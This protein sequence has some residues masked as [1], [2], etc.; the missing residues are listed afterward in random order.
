MPP[1]DVLTTEYYAGN[2]LSPIEAE[3]L[4][5]YQLLALQLNTL[6]AEIKKLNSA[7]DQN[8]LARNLSSDN[9]TENGALGNADQLVDNLR[10]L[11]MKMGLVY[12][13]FKGAVYSLFLQ[14]EEDQNLKSDE[15]KRLNEDSETED[16]N[17]EKDNSADDQ[18][19]DAES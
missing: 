10:S 17:E 12:T 1:K 11:E 18:S 4:S 5:Q 16:G 15:A 7:R 3:I 2:L 19:N 9:D 6:A 13:L 8:H 14:Y